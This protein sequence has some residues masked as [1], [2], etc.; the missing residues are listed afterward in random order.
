[1]RAADCGVLPAPARALPPRPL[2][3]PQRPVPPTSADPHQTRPRLAPTRPKH[4]RAPV[5]RRL[6]G[7]G[8]VLAGV[9]GH[10]R[11]FFAGGESPR[12][13][14]GPRSGGSAQES[15]VSLRVYGSRAG[16]SVLPCVSVFAGESVLGVEA[17][18]DLPPIHLLGH[19]KCHP[20]TRSL[21]MGVGWRVQGR[22]QVCGCSIH[23]SGQQG[24]GRCPPTGVAGD[25]PPSGAARAHPVLHPCW[26]GVL[27]VVAVCRRGGE[28]PG[29]S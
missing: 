9:V 27:R 4:A 3:L 15:N 20:G 22:H 12:R 8:A 10:G 2:A 28:T 14:G 16:V 26:D 5:E 24:A 23:A 6:G 11:A 1:M 25:I 29:R 13:W 7:A 19:M 18:T 21:M 17:T